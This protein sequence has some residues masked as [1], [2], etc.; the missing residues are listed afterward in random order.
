MTLRTTKTT[1]I[2]EGLDGVITIENPQALGNRVY[3][4]AYYTAKGNLH[5]SRSDDGSLWTAG[6]KTWTIKGKIATIADFTKGKYEV[7]RC[8]E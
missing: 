4:F 7:P 5:V 3:G 2:I 6:G 8:E 1:G